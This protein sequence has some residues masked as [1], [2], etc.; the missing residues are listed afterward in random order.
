M[1]NN[2]INN[3]I[4]DNKNDKDMAQRLA[5]SYLTSIGVIA[6][7]RGGGLW[8]NNTQVYSYNKALNMLGISI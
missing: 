3:I 8:V 7:I 2:I 4:K 5:V 1:N 6:H